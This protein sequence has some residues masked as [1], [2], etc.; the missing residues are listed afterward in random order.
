MIENGPIVKRAARLIC[1]TPEFDDLAKEIFGA[2][3]EHGQDGRATLAAVWRNRSGRAR[4]TPGGNGRSG[5]PSLR[6]DRRR[7]GLGG[8]EQI[9]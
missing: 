4:E 9:K 6:P 8:E 1:T 7:M 3:E 5:R 2:R